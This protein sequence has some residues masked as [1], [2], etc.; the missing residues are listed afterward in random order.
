MVQDSSG[1]RIRTSLNNQDS[2]DLKLF[3]KIKRF[4]DQGYDVEFKKAK[5]GG[6]K[7]LKVNKQ[8]IEQD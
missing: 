4:V 7:I 2:E 3:R 5:S 8:I 6:Y 1:S